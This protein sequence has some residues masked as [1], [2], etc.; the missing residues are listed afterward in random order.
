MAIPLNPRPGP[1][2]YI[3]IINP[4]RRPF[5]T[6]DGYLALLVYNDKQWT[7]FLHLIDR[8]DLIG[9][10]IFADMATRGQNIVEILRFCAGKVSAN[11]PRPS[12]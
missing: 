7:E 5:A 8:P 1:P 12:G 11:G 10:G 2:G 9:Q 4:N 3:R 6:R